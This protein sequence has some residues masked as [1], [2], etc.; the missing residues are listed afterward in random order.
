MER[1]TL[2]SS[3]GVVVMSVSQPCDDL[4]VD[5]NNMLYCSMSLAN[6]IVKSWLDDDM[7]TLTTVAGNGSWG[8]ASYMLAYPYGIFVDINFD[9]YVADSGNHRIQ[10]FPLGQ[11]NGITVAGIGSSNFTILLNSPSSVI[12]DADGYLFI[13]DYGDSRIV[14]SGPNG[15]RCV[16]GCNGSS[17]TTGYLPGPW[18]FKFD[19]YGNIFV[20][21]VNINSV[22]KL[23][24]LNNSCGEC[25]IRSVQI[26]IYETIVPVVLIS[27]QNAVIFSQNLSLLVVKILKPE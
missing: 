4:F 20:T 12:L 24:L 27:S 13:V 16:A 23:T 11:L 2:N 14:G 15:F 18:L 25:K 3:A 1:W 19:S 9:L 22:L 21:V 26:L 7:T 8:S 5:T 17:S 10:L 6:S